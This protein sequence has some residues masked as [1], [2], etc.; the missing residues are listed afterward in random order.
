[1]KPE[2]SRSVGRPRQRW[3]DSVEN[4]L[5]SLSIRMGGDWSHQEKNGGSKLSTRPWLSMGRSA[6]NDDDDDVR[7]DNTVINSLVNL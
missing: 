6:G 4:G 5:R 7:R 3:L 2:G 1:M